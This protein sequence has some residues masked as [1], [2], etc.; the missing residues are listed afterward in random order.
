MQAKG[1]TVGILV[2]FQGNVSRIG[3]GQSSDPMR[4]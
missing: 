3:S 4:G 1:G 2:I